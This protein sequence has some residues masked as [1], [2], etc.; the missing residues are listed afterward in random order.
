MMD[1]CPGGCPDIL[2]VP[3]GIVNIIVGR[4]YGAHLNKAKIRIRIPCF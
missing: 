4:R 2:P 1:P 3:A